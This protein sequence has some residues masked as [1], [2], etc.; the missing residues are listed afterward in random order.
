MTGDQ[1]FS[2]RY[3]IDYILFMRLFIQQQEDMWHWIRKTRIS[4]HFLT[5]CKQHLKQ[6][7]VP[8]CITRLSLKPP[9]IHHLPKSLSP[10]SKML[11]LATTASDV[12]F[13]YFPSTIN[14]FHL[15]FQPPCELILAS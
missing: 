12:G 8:L 6:A 1:D 14:S 2:Q 5:N 3:H 11:S 15:H 7:S 10:S 9:N 13:S 4:S